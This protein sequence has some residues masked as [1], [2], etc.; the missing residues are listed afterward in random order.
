MKLHTDLSQKANVFFTQSTW[1]PSP[2]KEVSRKMLERDGGEIATATTLV[3]YEPNS[4]FSLHV[5]TGGEE[6]LVLEG[7]FADEHGSYPIGT[8]VRNPIGTS[9]A[10][11]VKDGCMILVKLG[12]YQEGDTTPVHIKTQEQEFV[13]DDNRLGVLFQPLHHFKQE[14]VRLEKWKEG[15]IIELENHGGIEIL[16]V[17]GEFTHQSIR[18]QKFD[19]LR[20]P[21]GHL[22]QA[23]TAQTECLVWIKAGH[24]LHQRQA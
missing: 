16:V 12:Q 21:I 18:Y 15:Q 1:V 20:L 5:H 7:I 3:T 2:I 13:K 19:W 17:E 23:T 8:Y 22:L 4:Y 9:H 24:H 6:F 10:P 14:T 11:I